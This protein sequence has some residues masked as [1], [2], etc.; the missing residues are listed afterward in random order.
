MWR[1]HLGR[2]QACITVA[3]ALLLVTGLATGCTSTSQD[4][5]AANQLNVQMAIA[6]PQVTTLGTAEPVMGI[7]VTLFEDLSASQAR[8]LVGDSDTFSCDG[9]PL[10]RDGSLQYSFVGSVPSAGAQG[11]QSCS[12]THGG[13]TTRF[14]FVTP[15][16]PSV[17]APLPNA[18][19]SSAQ[20]L[21]VQFT[22]AQTVPTVLAI[23]GKPAI[24]LA[25]PIA[26]AILPPQVIQQFLLT[27]A[28]CTLTVSQT[29]R[30]T[31]ASDFNNLEIA[32][33]SSTIV[34]LTL[35]N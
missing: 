35:S 4:N 28:T 21:I 13:T 17:L 22:P 1:R 26:E 12:Y 2:H 25:A 20:N 7:K 27:T 23:D 10:V 30:L 9:A 16:R 14:S 18:R 8:V 11:N 24:T 15:Q 3:G 32:Y 31:P 29:S 19:A 6:D 33:T 34:P 5:L